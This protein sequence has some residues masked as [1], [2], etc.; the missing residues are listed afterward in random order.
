MK[1]GRI[2]HSGTTKV[3]CGRTK[4]ARS[5]QEIRY[6]PVTG[7]S[8]ICAP[9]RRQRP[10]DQSGAQHS[11]PAPEFDRDCP[12]CPG[13]E[14]QITPLI[15]Q[16]PTGGVAWQTRVVFNRYPVVT[17]ALDQ[18][19]QVQG[20]LSALPAR[21]RHEVIIESPKH[22]WDLSQA[23]QAE[24]EAVITT[25]HARYRALADDGG[26]AT[27]VP[28][29]N[30]GVRAGASLKHPHSQVVAMVRVTEELERR[31]TIAQA[32]LRR[33]GRCVVCDLVSAEGR[34]GRRLVFESAFF[35][36]FVPYA[37]EV[38]YEVW[39]VPK[40]HSESFA[41]VERELIRDLAM[42]LRDCLFRLSV[43][44]CLI[45]YNLVLQSDPETIG[46]AAERHWYLRMYPRLT[47][48]GGFELGSGMA[49]NPS[50]PEADA[51]DLREN[52]T[53]TGDSEIS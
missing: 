3:S 53:G 25:Y 47:S 5:L 19:A 16:Q 8:V 45:D 10:A 6:N 40:Q 33:T 49:I 32:Y 13:N 36:G 18:P 52:G 23:S 26:F 39:L 42:A 20:I 27:I 7:R 28:F 12:F 38:P 43:Q 17:S 48:P 35:L 31:R 46:P 30:G 4:P 1:K 15:D 37:A 34:H 41:Q 24:A 21:G 22:N 50:S 2:I 14:A 51:Q 29:R 44:G 9:S 11:V